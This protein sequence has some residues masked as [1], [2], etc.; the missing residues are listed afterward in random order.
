MFQKSAPL[1]SWVCFQ[2]F[3]ESEAIMTAEGRRVL[4]VF[5]ISATS[6]VPSP[7]YDTVCVVPV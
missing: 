6:A 4:R 5:I 3:A 2:V 1:K 7:V